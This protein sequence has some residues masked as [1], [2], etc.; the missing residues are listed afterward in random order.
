M[1]HSETNRAVTVDLRTHT[2]HP[3]DSSS[4]L[5]KMALPE[6]LLEKENKHMLMKA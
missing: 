4:R 2:E 5:S 1:V 6:V 3:G